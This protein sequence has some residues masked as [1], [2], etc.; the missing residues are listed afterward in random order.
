[1]GWAECEHSITIGLRPLDPCM[2]RVDVNAGHSTA[3][4]FC[5]QLVKEGSELALLS[6]L[7]LGE[8]MEG[9]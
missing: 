6:L 5:E 3:H 2:H 7:V 9:R 8:H 1:M 4:P